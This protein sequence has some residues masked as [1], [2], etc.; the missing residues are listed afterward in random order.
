MSLLFGLQE[1]ADR[2]NLTFGQVELI[3]ETAAGQANSTDVV[4]GSG[5]DSHY[6]L[7]T[8]GGRGQSWT[9]AKPMIL[10]AGLLGMGY[11]N[12]YS[13][14][15][16]YRD[17][18]NR[19]YFDYAHNDYLQFLIEFG[20]LGAAMFFCLAALALNNAIRTQLN[21]RNAIAISAAFAVMMGITSIAIH[22]WTDFNL[23]IPANAMLVTLL[24]SLSVLARWQ[25]N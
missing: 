1:L 24:L 2:M 21:R 23:Y 20:F 17:G 5:G 8:G 15:P 12:F 11:G 6:R 10:D 3:E 4:K 18:S 22:S 16:H 9:Q 14:Y 13:Q 7:V 25:K 19:G